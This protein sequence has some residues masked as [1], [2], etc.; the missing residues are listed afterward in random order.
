LES[1]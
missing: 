1:N